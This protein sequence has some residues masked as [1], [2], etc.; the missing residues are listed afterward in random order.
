MSAGACTIRVNPIVSLLF[1]LTMLVVAV[2]G[3]ES[4]FGDLTAEQRET[5]RAEAQ[6]QYDRGVSALRSNPAAAREAFADSAGRFRLLVA[7]GVVSGKLEY[8]LA[9]AYLQSGDLG[10]AI[11]HYR[12]A[13]RLIAG[14]PRL[15]RNLDYA[16]SLRR[17]QIAP[18][19][20]RALLQAL[21]I[22]HHR[23]P[24]PARFIVFASAYVIFWLVLS[25]RLFRPAPAWRWTALATAV[26]WIA[27]GA[28]VGVD[29]FG[30]E[31][32]VEGVVLADD[33]TVRKGNGEGYEAQFEQPLHRG[34]EF[35]VVESRGGWLNIELPDRKTGWIRADDAGL[36]G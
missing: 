36:I 8:N 17:N 12:R 11:L 25:M 21:L 31:G 30:G 22:W 6:A 7:D 10:R 20:E 14:D 9:N 18:A 28:S 26:L 29:L 15:E 13:E 27:C 23:T 2:A 34:V 19:G 3:A 1:A 24:V 16:R 32:D 4:A 33:V 5:I 35:T